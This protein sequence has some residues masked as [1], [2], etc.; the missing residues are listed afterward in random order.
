M[1]T[2]FEE[3][4]EPPQPRPRE[5]IPAFPFPIEPIDISLARW[6]VASRIGKLPFDG[7][8]ACTRSLWLVFAGDWGVWVRAVIPVDN[9]L[10]AEDRATLVAKSAEAADLLGEPECFGVAIAA[11][12]LR[13]PFPAQ[14][15]PGRQADLPPA[16]QGGHGQGHGP[17]VVLRRR[18]RRR[19]APSHA[20]GP[21]AVRAG[22]IIDTARAKAVP[23]AVSDKSEM[24]PLWG[25]EIQPTSRRCG[26][27]PAAPT[28]K[29]PSATRPRWAIPGRCGWTIP[30]APSSASP[31]PATTRPQR[32][33]R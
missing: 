5:D 25:T 15:H 13:R 8:E 31:C 7:Y 9:R 22:A 17:V 10:D 11:V 33:E 19:P 1:D 30:P 6:Q 18:T 32:A 23:P 21:G 16:D 28:P 26:D 4:A 20:S 24:P 29:N 12:V 14:A 2:Y 27:R 3:D